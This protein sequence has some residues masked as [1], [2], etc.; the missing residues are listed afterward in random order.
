M[1]RQLLKRDTDRGN[2]V[3]FKNRGRDHVQ[4]E[5]QTI[6]AEM[7]KE[8]DFS[9]EPLKGYTVLLPTP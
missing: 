5:G 3:G 1:K 9:L 8:T 7:A 6:E 2:T 4:G